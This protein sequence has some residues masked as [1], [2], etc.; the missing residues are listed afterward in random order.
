MIRFGCSCILSLLIFCFVV[1][2]AGMSR[3]EERS[4]LSAVAIDTDAVN[5]SKPVISVQKRRRSGM[6]NTFVT[7]TIDIPTPTAHVWKSMVSCVAAL[8]IVPNLQDC[9]IISQS[10]ID[11]REDQYWDIRR[12]MIRYGGIFPKTI[13]IFRSTYQFQR[14]IDFVRT[15]GD[16]R[17]MKGHWRL[18]PFNNGSATRVF[19]E[20][21]IGLGQPVPKLLVR[22]V[23]K[24][25]TAKI[26]KRLSAYAQA[27]S[28]SSPSEASHE[29]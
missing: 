24:S 27:V 7:A 20:A 9:E 23:V 21:E 11:P 19:Y 4:G 3:A 28:R 14:Q 10:E 16:L 25:D 26:L 29:Q 6:T 22:R 1:A 17:Y 18:Q 15:G 2:D 5:F 13:N 8:E 12:H